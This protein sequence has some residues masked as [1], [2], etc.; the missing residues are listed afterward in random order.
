MNLSSI[1][2]GTDNASHNWIRACYPMTALIGIS[3][4]I[5]P[6]YFSCGIWR[7]LEHDETTAA[8]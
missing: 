4:D 6:D 7:E 1:S 3:Y 2:C 8:Q 5:E